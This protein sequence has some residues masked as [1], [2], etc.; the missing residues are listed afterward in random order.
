MIFKFI[1]KHKFIFKYAAVYVLAILV[2]GGFLGGMAL[3]AR[4]GKIEAEKEFYGGQ[5][6]NRN[7][8]PEYLSKDIDFNL[9][10]Q[11]WDL[12]K[13]DYVHQPVQDT[14]L[15]YGALAGII[16]SLDDPYS[17]FFDPQTAEDFKKELEGTFSG[18]GAE[19]GIKNKQLT[20]IA[21]LPDTPAEKAGLKAG[22]RILAID[23]KDTTDMALDYAVS[24]IRGEKG[25]DVTLTI[26]RE[27]WEKSEDFKITR[28]Q[29][30]VASVKW[31]M[32]G[33][34]AYIEINHFNEDTTRR[35]NQA[36]TELIAKNP[37]GLILDLRNN[38]GGFLDTAV[39]VAGEWVSNDVIV[40]EQMDDGQK[41][42]ERSS[43]LARLEN[44]KTVVLVN[45]GSAS[46]SEIVG[47][48][49][50]DYGKATLVG[51]KTFGKGSVQNLEPLPD[52][53]AVKITVAEWLTPKGRQIDKE[54][55]APD[56][57]IKLTEEDYNANRDPQ[58][59]KAIEIINSPAK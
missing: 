52:G 17:V 1:E 4:Q 53:S 36:V 8:I 22:D 28:D 27:G 30:E 19:L 26:W 35:F 46:A 14:K 3:G 59:D 50:Q 39:E 56:V 29:I 45:Q 32:K 55:I 2:L 43:G 49:L 18:I 6:Q 51:E 54:G 13:N 44:L 21:P 58:M 40:V 25:T 38:P 47:G 15:F 10:W 31:E 7:Q 20:I 34:I 37:K 9:F 41:N 23:G 11:V 16:S 24:I 42:E 57:E 48:A 12:A 33:D 5:V